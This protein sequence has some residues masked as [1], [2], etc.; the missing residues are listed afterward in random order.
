MNNTRNKTILFCILKTISLQIRALLVTK[1]TLRNSLVVACKLSCSVACA[2]LVSRLGIEPVTP[3]LEGGFFF[4]SLMDGRWILN[5]WTT[6][7]VPESSL[8]NIGSEL[9]ATCLIFFIGVN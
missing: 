7:E 8:L 1:Q 3:M 4:F 6:S 9:I 2:I 5:H